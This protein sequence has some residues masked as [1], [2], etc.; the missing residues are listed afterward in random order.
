MQSF[1]NFELI[2][3]SD[4]KASE[5]WFDPSVG[6]ISWRRKWQPI[7]VLLPGKF[8][9]QRSLVGYSPWDCRES[10]MTER[11]QCQCQCCP[12]S[13]SNCCS[14]TRIQASQVT[15]RVVW[16]SCF[17]KNF[18]QFVVIH[19]VKRFGIVNEVEVDVLLEFPCFLYDTANVGNLISG[20]SAFLN[21]ACTSGISW[22]T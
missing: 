1:S 20:S 19:T 21:P 12:M 22:F 18:P 15:V 10:D 5:T 8:L 4:S 9:G 7:L 6:K 17:L 16:Y 11:L 3:G 14:L 13:S 2:G